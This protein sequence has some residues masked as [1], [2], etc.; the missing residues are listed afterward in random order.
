MQTFST[1]NQIFCLF[2]AILHIVNISFGQ[3]VLTL[4]LPD[5]QVVKTVNVE[6][7]II[8]LH[9]TNKFSEAIK[10]FQVLKIQCLESRGAPTL[11]VKVTRM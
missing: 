4:Y 1:D 6:H 7:C 2:I 8:T 10:T 5:G 11:R 9:Y 3:P